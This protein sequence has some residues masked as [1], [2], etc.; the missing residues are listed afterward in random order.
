MLLSNLWVTYAFTTFNMQSLEHLCFYSFQDAI[1][2]SFMLLPYSKCNIW[3]IYAFTIFEMQYLGHVCF[4]YVHDAIV[5]SLML[6]NI[7]NVI[8][9]PRKLLLYT[10]CNRWVTYA[11]TIYIQDGIFGSLMLYLY[12]R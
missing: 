2:V 7:Q 9:G 12:S 4:N 10:R 1:L 8:F 11:F 3:V 5:G 6:C